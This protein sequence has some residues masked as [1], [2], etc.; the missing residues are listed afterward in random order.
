[1]SEYLKHHPLAHDMPEHRDAIHDLKMSDEHFSRLLGEYE[2]LD[3]RIVRIEQRIE[4]MD[5]LELD[6]LKMERVAMK[7]TLVGLL[8]K[9]S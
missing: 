3:K 1:M 5:D 6:N 8:Q 7:D 2:V 9:T 4:L